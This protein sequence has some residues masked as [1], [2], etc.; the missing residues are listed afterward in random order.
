MAQPAGTVGMDAE[1]ERC[2]QNCLECH[3]ICLETIPHCLGMGGVHAA[4]M[5]I[6]LLQDCAQICQTSADFMIRG[7]NL[8]IYTCA[9][10]AEVCDRCADDCERIDKNDGQMKACADL[11]RRCAASCH[12]MSGAKAAH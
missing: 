2:I 1:M 10:C 3:R 12:R 4:P 6:R 11:C 9:A 7:S 5:H 8:H